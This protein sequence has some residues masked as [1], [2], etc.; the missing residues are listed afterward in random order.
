[1][2][3]PRINI[4]LEPNTLEVLNKI[5]A[6]QD[7][8]IATIARNFIIES[9]ERYEDQAL[10]QIAQKRDKLNNKLV[11]HKKAWN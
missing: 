5:A 4:T 10:S 2:K 9:I 3:N 8:A 6:K 7:I 11:D 1:M